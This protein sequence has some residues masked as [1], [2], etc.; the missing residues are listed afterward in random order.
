MFNEL[1][2]LIFMVG[3]V[4]FVIG[5]IAY[6]HAFYKGRKRDNDQKPDL[7]SAALLKKEIEQG[8]HMVTVSTEEI[9]FQPQRW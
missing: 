4:G 7:L 1:V 9:P 3:M 2:G 5:F 6:K 8:K